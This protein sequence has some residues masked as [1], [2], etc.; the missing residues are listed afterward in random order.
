MAQKAQRVMLAEK[1]TE[2]IDPTGFLIFL[3]L[4]VFIL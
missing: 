2:D 3:V 1:H 4:L